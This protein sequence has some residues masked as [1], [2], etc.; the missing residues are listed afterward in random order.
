MVLTVWDWKEE[1]RKLY[2]AVAVDYFKTMQAVPRKERTR[3]K[4]T[5]LREAVGKR[6]GISLSTVYRA[7]RAALRAL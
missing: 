5:Q 4:I 6:H 2:E 3:V 7:T 1:K